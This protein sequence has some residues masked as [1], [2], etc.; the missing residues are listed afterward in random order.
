MITI[1]YVISTFCYLNALIKSMQEREDVFI[2]TL[3][4]RVSCW[5]LRTDDE[6][7]DAV[8]FLHWFLRSKFWRQKKERMNVK[9]KQIAGY[10]QFKIGRKLY[11]RVM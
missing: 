4:S 11:C 1:C 9:F 2:K 10:L 6:S 8:L 3:S 5:R 7:W